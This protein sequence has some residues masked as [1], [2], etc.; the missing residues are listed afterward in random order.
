VQR[1]M[2]VVRGRIG[3]ISKHRHSG[4]IS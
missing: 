1:L 2:A 4:I 3:E